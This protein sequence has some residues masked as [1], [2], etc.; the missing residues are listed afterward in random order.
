MTEEKSPKVVL[1]AW[2]W[3][4]DGTFGRG[5]G[6]SDLRPV[7][8]AAMGAGLNL[9]DTAYVYG[10]GTSER[11]LASFLKGLPREGFCV[12]DKLTPQCMDASSETAV[13]DMYGMQLRTMGLDHFDVYWVHN[14]VDA[15]R[16]ISEL[17]AFFEGRDDAPVIGVSNHNLS[18]IRQADAILREHG[19]RLGA[20]QNHFSLVNRSSEDS[21]I[22]AWC[23]ENDVEFWSYMVLEQGAL[24]GTYDT[25]HPMPAGSARAL[26]Y[27]PVLDRLEVLN[28]E[29]A[30][31]AEAHGVGVAQI[32]VAWAIAKGT[33]PIVGVTRESHVTDVV[34]ASS[35]VLSADEVRELERVADSL[36]VDAV[37]AWEKKMD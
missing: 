6:E 19:L 23:R 37:R 11:V 34:R 36:G 27:N 13:A 35:V 22:L 17:A 10:M 1:G 14:T 16:W 20:V 2:A 29:L 31:V 32:P 28:A 33:R 25:T 18:E 5:L 21:G 15:P 26:K 3:G 30:K 9:W 8:D 24:S 4:N 7:F 12:S